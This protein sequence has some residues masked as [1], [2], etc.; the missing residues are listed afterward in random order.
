[1]YKKIN[2]YLL[3]GICKIFTIINTVTPKKKNRIIFFTN[4]P[5][6]ID[7]N[8]ALFEYLVANNYN[9]KYLIYYSSP[10]PK[11]ITQKEKNIRHVSPYFG[12]VLFLFSKYC[13]YDAGTFKIKPTSKQ[14]VISIWHGTPLKKIG[15]SVENSIKL[16]RYNDF[17]KIICTSSNLVPIFKKA[18]E[19]TEVDIIVMGYPRNDYLFNKSNYLGYFNID[20]EKYSKLILWMP[21]F[22]KSLNNRYIDV[23]NYSEDAWLFPFSSD[24]DYTRLDLFLKKINTYLVIKLHPL[25][26]QNKYNYP[27]YE[28][29]KIIKN[30]DLQRINL[31]NYKFVSSFDALITDYSSVYFD[32]LLL[33]RP[34]GF[35]INDINSYSDNRGFS[36]SNPLSMMPGLKISNAMEFY[37]FINDTVNGNDEY[38]EQ[39]KEVNSIINTY[40]DSN[41]S[42]RLLDYCGISI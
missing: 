1:M 35:I 25:S 21:T 22:K 32:F 42:K 10:D 34:I 6:F 20:K 17:S 27:S 40:T 41:S 16:D 39:R 7:N 23:A 8:R 31:H 4:I 33:D 3:L 15:R 26:I 30:A 11:F 14:I 18:F 19:C 36:F 5:N 13:F 24:I 12:A 9:R 29:M 2:R 28:N 37:K 38:K